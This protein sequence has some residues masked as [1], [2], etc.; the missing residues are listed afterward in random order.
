MSDATR[1]GAPG[2]SGAPGAQRAGIGREPAPGAPPPAPWPRMALAVLS[3]VGVL[4]AGYLLLHRLGLVGRLLC[5]PEGSCETVQASAY[6]IFAGMPVPA[7]GVAGYLVVLLISLLGL[8]PGLTEDRRVTVALVALTLV[9]LAFTAYLNA[10]EAYVI[11]AWCRW[12]IASAIVVALSFLC[13]LAD[14]A[15]V[16]G[17]ARAVAAHSS[18]EAV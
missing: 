18:E 11:H 15:T 6:A 17:R 9:A 8:R 5:G 4:I 12:C 14:L 1:P 16:A 13:A 3:L 7:I 2:A 10:L